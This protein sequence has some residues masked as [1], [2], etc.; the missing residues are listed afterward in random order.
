[1]ASCSKSKAIMVVLVGLFGL[2][3]VGFAVS[4]TEKYRLQK[5][6]VHGLER[7]LRAGRTEVLKVPDLMQKLDKVE[8]SKKEIES[9][10]AECSEEKEELSEKLGELE[11]EVGSFGAV[12]AAVGIQIAGLETIIKEQQQNVSEA[13]KNS[14]ELAGQIGA[15]QEM[16]SATEEKFKLQID[17]IKRGQEEVKNQ[18][19]YYT[20]AKKISDIEIEEK[21]K[22]IQ[23]LE[24]ELARLKSGEETSSA[25]VE[26]RAVSETQ[27]DL[28]LTEEL[29]KTFTLLRERISSPTMSLSEVSTLLSRAEHALKRLK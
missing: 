21:K 8:A 11:V 7:Q 3:C 2:L 5:E 25:P 26:T 15:L 18:L 22:I 23:A 17:D 20:E 4:V 10:F 19:I 29:D 12:K 28:N 27:W 6:R 13:E 24:T 16:H 9:T 14:V 1:M